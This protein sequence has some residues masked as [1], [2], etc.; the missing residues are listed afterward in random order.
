MLTG[1]QSIKQSDFEICYAATRQT[2]NSH[3]TRITTDKLKAN[4]HSNYL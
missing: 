4:I 2:V 1:L 3:L